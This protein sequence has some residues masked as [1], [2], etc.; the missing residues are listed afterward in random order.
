ML[1]MIGSGWQ[2]YNAAPI[3]PFTFPRAITLGGWLGGAIAWHLAA[4]WTLG[5]AG[6]VYAIYGLTSGHF[7]RD[8]SLPSPR[9]FVHDMVLALRFHLR[10][11]AGR[12][13]AVQRA[14]YIGVLLVSLVTVASGFSIWKPVQFWWLTELFGGFDVAR[15]FHFVFMTLIVAFLIVHIA[16]VLIV[17]S[18]LFGMILGRRLI[19]DD[20]KKAE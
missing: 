4:M 5:G 12:Y 13:N 19:P 14:L 11:E 15:R 8:L 3:L 9:A 16:L 18:T 6:L 20:G 10:H 1:V 7:R 17:P 2:I